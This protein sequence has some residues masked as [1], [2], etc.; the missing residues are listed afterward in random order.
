MIK[1]FVTGDVHLGKKYDRYPQIRDILIRSRFDCL[2]D[3]VMRAEAECCDLFAVTGDLFD[4][5]NTVKTGDVKKAAGILSE[6]NG[7]VLI[8]PG[9]HDYYTGDEKVW[10]DFENA[11]A[12][13]DHNMII[14][15]EFREYPFDIGDDRVVFYPAYCQSKHSKE[16]NLEWIRNAAMD[17]EAINIGIA[18]G[19]LKGL[20]PDIKE[21]YFP[22]SESELLAMPADVW[23]LGHTHIPYPKDLETDRD[24]TG[25]RIFNP[26]THEQTDLSNNTEGCCFIISVEKRR[27]TAKVSARKYVSGKIRYYDL[28]IKLQGN[29]EGSLTDSLRTAVGNI[30]ERS[31]VRAGLSGTVS[32]Q[33]YADRQMIYRELLSGFLS[34][35]VND[36]E[37]SEEITVERIQNEFADTSFAAGLLE[38]FLEK[39]AELQMVYQLLQEC[40]EN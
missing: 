7:T 2:R 17:P 4:S 8:L 38:Q 22:M 28:A 37:L 18:H 29:Q 36:S 16:N 39:P 3:M 15:N 35:E 23:L 32:R 24:I 40:R 34:Y 27:G 11:L 33:D 26:G 21:E 5:I 12:G 20:A 10:K 25:Y 13:L 14:L 30:P 6:F 31:V 19:A 9:N 1:L